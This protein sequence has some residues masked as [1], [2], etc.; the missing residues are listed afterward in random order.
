MPPNRPPPPAGAAPVAPLPYGMTPAIESQ[1]QGSN[2]TNSRPGTAGGNVNPL[3]GI[4]WRLNN[5]YN[6]MMEL[7]NLTIPDI[8]GKTLMDIEAKYAY[9]FS[10][11]RGIMK[12]A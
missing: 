12:S 1:G 2:A 5:K 6:A 11:E 8:R 9:D 3:T 10:I 7:Q 4:E